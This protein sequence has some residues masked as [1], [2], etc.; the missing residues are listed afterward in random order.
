MT[1]YRD[2]QDL[3]KR[4]MDATFGVK[5]EESFIDL[6]GIHGLQ[7]FAGLPVDL[8]VEGETGTGK[9]TVARVIHQRHYP[10]CPFVSVN[11]AAIPEALMESELFGVEA[12]AYTGAVRARPGKIEIAN[13]GVLYLDEIDS[14]TLHHQAKLLQVLQYRGSTRLGG[15]TFR[16]SRFRLIT[17]TKTP[18][19]VLVQR[20]QF[21]SDLYYRLNTVTIPLPP[22]RRQVARIIPTFDRMLQV[23]APRLGQTIQPLRASQLDALR[24]HPWPG[25]YR[26]LLGCAIRHLCGQTILDECANMAPDAALDTE[27]GMLI[28][29][30]TLSLKTRIRA[31][32]SRLITM[33]LD[34]S[35]GNVAK[36]ASLLQMSS[37]TLHYRIRA[38]Q[39]PTSARC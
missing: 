4:S 38:L 20:G 26:E 27:P 5:G 2:E 1:S 9:D 19:N 36:A 13:G 11:C 12:G 8:V 6:S 21:R 17:S 25:N 15:N 31:F 37:Q 10:E 14:M 33:A 18:L 16:P 3:H 23:H 28:D 22:L 32:E 35:S 39:L 34:S 30:N 24:R 29:A 7:H